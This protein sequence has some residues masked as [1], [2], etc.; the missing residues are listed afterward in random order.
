M[1]SKKSKL[2]IKSFAWKK[3]LKGEYSMEIKGNEYLSLLQLE[4]FY[5]NTEI[6]RL[7]QVVV[8][9][10]ITIEKL[11]TQQ[12]ELES[13]LAELR[14]FFGENKRKRKFY[15]E[16]GKKQQENLQTNL[17]HRSG[18]MQAIA[19]C[20]GLRLVEMVSGVIPSMKMFKFLS[21]NQVPKKKVKKLL[22]K[23]LKKW[24]K[25]LRKLLK[26]LKK[27]KK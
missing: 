13:D 14:E 21:I 12:E 22:R 19:K 4:L 3:W 5:A 20:Y 15:H 6:E 2:G 25:L 27:L 26:K 18:F 11:F 8:E 16:V 1:N 10:K 17:K 24:K 23:L 9:Q 7:Q